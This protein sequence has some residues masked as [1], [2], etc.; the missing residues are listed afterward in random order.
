MLGL[1]A[2]PPAH[3]SLPPRGSAAVRSR[4]LASFLSRPPLPTRRQEAKALSAAPC[5]RLSSEPEFWERQVVTIPEVGKEWGPREGRLN[6]GGPTGGECPLCF[7]C[8]RCARTPHR[9]DGAAASPRSSGGGQGTGSRGP[10]VGTGRETG[11]GTAMAQW[12]RSRQPRQG[13]FFCACRS[14]GRMG[15]HGKAWRRPTSLLITRKAGPDWFS[16]RSSLRDSCSFCTIPLVRS[17]YP[18]SRGRQ[19]HSWRVLSRTHGS[20]MAGLLRIPK[21]T[22]WECHLDAFRGLT[23][24]W[25]IGLLQGSPAGHQSPARLSEPWGP[26][27]SPHL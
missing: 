24:G 27:A 2:D 16:E 10:P 17:P 1:G 18:M 14:G 5:T 15:H 21:G 22:G 13:A 23:D 12:G 4:L 25:P 8:T 20:R 19:G 11:Q 6:A 9:A 7:R 3:P 26:V